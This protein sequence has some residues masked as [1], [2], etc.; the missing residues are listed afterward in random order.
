MEQLFLFYSSNSIVY[1]NFYVL[2]SRREDKRFWTEWYQALPEFPLESV[3]DFYS[4]SQ[5]SELHHIFKIS[6]TYLNVM[7][8][9]CILVTGQQHILSLLWVYFYTSLFIGVNQSLCVFFVVYIYIVTCCVHVT[10]QITS[11]RI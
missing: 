8:L 10:R 4:H 6:V 5:I 1:S 7:I 9:P 2:D 11:R 3:F